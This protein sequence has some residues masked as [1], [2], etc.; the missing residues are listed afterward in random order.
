MTLAAKKM[1]TVTLHTK[2]YVTIIRQE[3][4]GD[5]FLFK[6]TPKKSTIWNGLILQNI[7]SIPHSHHVSETGYGMMLNSY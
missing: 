2:T 4:G 3:R 5:T 6:I 7:A 1:K